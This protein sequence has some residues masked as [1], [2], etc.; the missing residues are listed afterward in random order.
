MRS[1]PP[2]LDS[3]QNF[4]KNRLKYKHALGPDEIIEKVKY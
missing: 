4:L 2:D 3:M 1:L